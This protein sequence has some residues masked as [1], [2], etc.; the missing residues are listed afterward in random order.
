MS[1]IEL[2]LGKIIHQEEMLN[3][4]EFCRAIRADQEMISEMIEFNLLEP[5][6][7]S[8]QNWRFDSRCLK[9]AQIAI[10]FQRDLEIN[11]QGIALALDLLEQIERL[12]TQLEILRK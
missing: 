9:R 2:I 11:Y 1:E 3:L 7:S 10:R 6:G 8:I 5:E 12:E 4:A